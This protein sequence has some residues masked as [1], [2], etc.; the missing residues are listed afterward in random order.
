MRGSVDALSYT[1]GDDTA[2]YRQ[3]AARHRAARPTKRAH[4][5]GELPTDDRA[6][7]ASM[8]KLKN[9]TPLTLRSA[10]VSAGECDAHYLSLGWPTDDALVVVDGD[11]GDGD[12]AVDALRLRRALAAR[13][14]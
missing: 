4:V 3:V 13:M 8:T 12:A 11:V 14:R 7:V 2:P 10:R 6:A 5:S 9:T 1:G